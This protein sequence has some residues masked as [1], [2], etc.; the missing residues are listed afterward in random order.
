MRKES[1]KDYFPLAFTLGVLL[2]GYIMYFLGQSWNRDDMA[3]LRSH[4]HSYQIEQ[5]KPRLAVPSD[6]PREHSAI[7]SQTST[8]LQDVKSYSDTNSTKKKAKSY[9][10]ME[11]PNTAGLSGGG[12]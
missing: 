2:T 12:K 3:L 5:N 10:N 4:I 7:T 9:Y 8:L 6:L 11:K 1:S